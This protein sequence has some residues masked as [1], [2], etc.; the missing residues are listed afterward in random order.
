[1][2]PVQTCSLINSQSVW[3]SEC[4]EFGLRER[5]HGTN[6]RHSTFLQIDLKVVQSVQSLSAFALLKTSAKSWYSSGM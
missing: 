5:V 3:I 4:L 6:Q 1:M 2:N